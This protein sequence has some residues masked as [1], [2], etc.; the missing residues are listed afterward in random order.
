MSD[1]DD[2]RLLD[3]PKAPRQNRFRFKS[4][5]DRVA[6]V[7]VDV[8]RS[9]TPVKAEPG[10]A[11]WLADALGQWRELNSAAHFLQT[12]AALQPFSHSLP[13]LLHSR[14]DACRILLAAL[15]PAA[16]LSLPGLLALLAALKARV[17]GA[18]AAAAAAAG[19]AVEAAG[20]AEAVGE[21]D[22]ERRRSHAGASSSAAAAA[23][24]PADGPKR[25]GAKRQAR[26][27]AAAAEAAAAAAAA[28]APGSKPQGAAQNGA[29]EPAAE[30]AADTSG[31][32]SA[33]ASV[34]AFGSGSGVS[35][36]SRIGG[37]TWRS[38]LLDWLRLLAG[39]RGVR[40]LHGTEE[41]QRAVASH[42]LEADSA[43]Q[44]AA[45]RC[46]RPYRFRWLP[47]ELADRLA[48]LADDSTLRE[49]LA[50]FPSA[51]DADGGV[52]EESRPG[53]VPLLVRVLFP[54][55]RKRSGR[56]GGRG[57]PGSARAA[58]LNALASLRPAELRPMIELLLEPMAAAFL[59]PAAAATAAADALSYRD[60][61]VAAEAAAVE[62]DRWRL[63]PPAWW[64]APMLGRSL[65]WWLGVVDQA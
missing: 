11:T 1:S 17:S 18:K 54:K 22:V 46:L 60:G 35:V 15:Q 41:V 45:L 37:K 44:V 48:R 10:G 20:G 6:E 3:A 16:R 9:L 43:V 19:A 26:Q 63:L 27:A 31:P 61:G 42:L 13:L 29:A 14:E 21:A 58:I 28:A 5:A 7:D 39:L 40:G 50:I 8:Y 24:S 57:A 51:P 4:F 62:A 64:S 32:A 56:L 23:P 38:G 59:Q 30:T 12:A 47:V 25:A 52:A 55:M 33:A 49:E 53:L 65:G 34:G 36:L 2:E